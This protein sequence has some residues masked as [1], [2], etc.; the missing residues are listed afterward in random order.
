MVSDGHGFFY[1]EYSITCVSALQAVPATQ[2]PVYARTV[3]CH[4]VMVHVQIS[5][6]TLKI[7]GNADVRYDNFF[8][9]IIFVS[10]KEEVLI[11]KRSLLQ[12]VSFR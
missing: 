5:H 3:A 12:L 2:D 10:A 7:A 8:L 4:L 11:F 6:P 9:D 1:C